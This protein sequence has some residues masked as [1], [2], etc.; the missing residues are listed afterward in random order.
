MSP[1]ELEAIL[2]GVTLEEVGAAIGRA[3]DA[4]V[5]AVKKVGQALA[6]FGQLLK[7]FFGF[8]V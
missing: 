1:D 6:E 3:G 5:V 7:E 2:G 4:I 8:G